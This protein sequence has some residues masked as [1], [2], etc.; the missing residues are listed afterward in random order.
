MRDTAYYFGRLP[1]VNRWHNA[2]AQRTKTGRYCARIFES[3][4]YKAL[5]AAIQMEFRKQLDPVPGYLDVHLVV[6]K[7]RV[8]D[9]DGPV[10]GILDA[11]QA[12]KVIKDDNRVRNILI[13]RKYHRKEEEDW[14]MITLKPLSEEEEKILEVEFKLK[15][16]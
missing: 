8:A 14:M 11:L 13:T 2:V 7:H 5:K 4:E 16:A 10:K 9:T 12:S 6:C 1:R 15:K 3:P